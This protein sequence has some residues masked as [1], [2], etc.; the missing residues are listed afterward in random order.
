MYNIELKSQIFFFDHC[1]WIISELAISRFGYGKAA[2]PVGF[3]GPVPNPAR[4]TC[5]GSRL[6]AAENLLAN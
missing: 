6:Q 5:I 1:I 3:G 2:T 4:I